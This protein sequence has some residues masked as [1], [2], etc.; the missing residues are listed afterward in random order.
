MANWNPW[1]GCQKLSPGCA[2]CYVYRGDSRRGRDAAQVYR[3][4]TYDLPLQKKRDGS[5]KV[6]AGEMVWTCFTSDFLLEEADQWRPWAWA[7]MQAR[8]DLHFFFI[9]KR[10]H[11]LSDHL[12]PDWS[13]GYENVGIA[14]TAEDQRRAEQ[15]LPHLLAAPIRHKSIACEPLLGPIDLRPWLGPEITQV[16]AGGESG[17]N[18]RPCRYEWILD[19]RRQCVEAG[20]PFLFKQTGAN[21]IKDGTLYRIPRKLQ[22]SQAR[23]AGINY[24][25]QTFLPLHGGRTW[26]LST[27]KPIH[28]TRNEE[29]FYE[30]DPL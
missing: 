10:I 13:Q 6:P 18:A 2:N 24:R 30:Y 28:P 9:T 4:K 5:W 25:C 17:P 11:R 8:A 3:T 21:F 14:S 1:H 29:I 7:M 23:R 16:V 22:H 27:G 26:S 19:L 20:V 15:R 12:P